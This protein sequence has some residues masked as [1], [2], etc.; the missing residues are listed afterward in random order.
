V[1]FRSDAVKLCN[2]PHDVIGGSY[3]GKSD[4]VHFH[5]LNMKPG[6]TKLMEV[7]GL[8]GGFLKITRRALEKIARKF[9]DLAFEYNG[10]KCHGWFENAIVDGEYLTEDYA[11]T[12]RWKQCGGKAFM[13]PDMT[14]SH[15]G[16]KVWQGNLHDHILKD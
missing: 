3:P 1:L 16:N 13:D 10:I 8:P 5:G 14:F 15:F 6:P 2:S 11:F 9:P 4:E 12:W 7:D